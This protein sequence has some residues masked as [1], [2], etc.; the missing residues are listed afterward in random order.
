MKLL[1]IGGDGTLGTYT[2]EELLAL[3]HSVE[4]LCPIKRES[5]HRNLR[6][7][8]GLG[9]Y[10]TLSALF[11][12]THYDGIVNF[13]HYPNA[14]EYPEI[15]A[16]LSANTEHL[17]FLSSY[18]VYADLQHPITET[19][20]FLVDTVSDPAFLALETYA[21]SKS[22][23]EAFLQKQEK[24]NWTIVRP[25]I[26]FSANRLDVVLRSGREVLDAARSKQPLLL[27]AE[28]MSLTA[29]LDWAGNTGKLIAHLLFRQAALGEAFTVSS[30]QNLT[31]KQVADCYT[32]LLGTPFTWLDTETYLKL[33]QKAI[34]DPWIL[35]YDRLFDRTID[36]RKILGVTG[37]SDSSFRSIK[38][39]ILHEI[40]KLKQEDLA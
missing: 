7:H 4:I 34:Q 8:Q 16:L 37:L 26:S 19:A 5:N 20:P 31:W 15:H 12:T 17:I 18:R 25:V 3:G 6:F 28:S 27:P 14:E 21:V 29:G 11:S 38:D 35:K 30:A 1:L 39:G 33:D 23:E 10:K 32:E 9:D 22:K 36:N 13:L 24:K 2:T 40:N